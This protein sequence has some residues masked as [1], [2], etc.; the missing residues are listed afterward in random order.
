MLFRSKKETDNL[1]K[2]RL[3]ELQKE[4][5][6]LRDAFNNKKAQW[7]NEKNSVN[8]LQE[9]R[10]QVEQVKKEIQ[11][12]QSKYDLEKMAELQYG[13]LPQ[14][15]KQLESEEANVKNKDLSLVRESVT[16]EEIAKIISRWTGIPVAKLTE[17]ERNKTLHLDEQLHKRVIGQDEAVTKITES[18]IR[19]KAGIK[20]P[21]KP[22]GSF[23][24]LGPTGVGKT[25]LAKALAQ[26]LFDDETNMVRI[27]MSEYMEKYSV[28]RLIG[29]PP[30]Y[31]GYD[32]GG[33]L[34]EAVRRKPYSVVLFDEIEK[35]HP[36]VFNVLLQ[37]LDDGRIT[38]SQ[39]RTVDFKNTILI[40]TSNIGSSYLLEGIND[41]G[42]IKPEAEEMVMNDL[43]NHFRP[44]FLNRLD[45]IIMF[46]P[47]TRDNIGGIVDLIVANLNE[48]LADKDLHLVLTDEA[49]KFVA[50]NGYDPVYGARPLKRYLQKN[51]ETLVAKIILQG[52]V[53]MGDTITVDAKDGKLIIR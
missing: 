33:Q 34:T 52:D 1:S 6:E 8:K 11:I 2:E 39:G 46:K 37:V 48:R 40:M 41:N 23:L 27:D 50:D 30:G 43:R 3:E 19:S 9:L 26:N 25:E 13:R 44:E 15:Q 38:D 29:A 5:A 10:E 36:D 45:E 22:I 51:V 16:D 28:S 21:G 42:D 31:V 20:D 24:F 49:K 12:A 18:I 7:E 4:L 14:L 35:A 32:E 17:T 47:L 53:N